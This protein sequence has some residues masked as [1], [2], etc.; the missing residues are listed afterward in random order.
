MPAE[1]ITHPFDHAWSK[2]SVKF[3]RDGVGMAI[4]VTVETPMTDEMRLMVL[5]SRAQLA[6]QRAE[7]EVRFMPR[8]DVVKFYKRYYYRNHPYDLEST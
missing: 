8:E 3:A 7:L 6:V 4:E 2:G 1:A 5:T